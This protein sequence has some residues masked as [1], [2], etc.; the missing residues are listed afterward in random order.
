MSISTG[1][2]KALV[3]GISEYTKLEGLN[4]CKNDGTEVYKVLSSLGYEIS[5]K[6]KLLG[7][8]KGAE[9]KDV[10]YD[11]FGDIGVNPD[12]TLLFYYSGHGVFDIDG[13]V[14]LA[15][16]DIDPEEPYRRG[17]SME[18]LTKMMQRSISTKV[19]VILDCCHSGSAKVS[20]GN[21]EDAAN[22][23]LKA[24][25][26]KSKKLQGQRKCILAACQAAQFAYTTGEHSLFTRY[27]LQGLN[28]D[29][30]SIDNDGNVTPESLGNYVERKIMKLPDN[31]RRQRPITR[32]EGS[33]N[34]ILASYPKL[35]P[36][37]IEDTLA[38]MLTL[39]REGNVQEFN[40]MREAN[41]AIIPEPDFSM[42]NLHGAHIAGANL[43]NAN[44]KRINLSA[45]DL[46]EANLSNANLFR[47][48]LEEANLSKT[49]FSK[50]ILEASNLS[51]A[52]LTKSNLSNA[53][54][55]K[56]NLSYAN[57]C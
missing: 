37:K 33:G 18:E 35:K 16:S 9:V 32:A 15:S 1:A 11:F 55:T 52:N 28:G 42:G 47:A 5:D 48:D 31:N 53:N 44:L 2:Q 43:S 26:E 25:D 22:K 46:E 21:A 20:K 56:S 4:I 12:D 50:A 6:N 27:L 36:L 23:A 38:S 49:N 7:E 13:D 10:I 41:S 17:F 30:E 14:Y 19:V 45:A 29:T 40:K 34:I 51:N 8:A 54:L 3:I 24:I 39:L 57:I